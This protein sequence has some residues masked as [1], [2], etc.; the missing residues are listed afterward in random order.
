MNRLFLIIFSFS[1]LFNGNA[2]SD[3]SRVNVERRTTTGLLDAQDADNYISSQ[4]RVAL[5]MDNGFVERDV[6]I[7]TRDGVV[8]LTGPVMNA[9]V[10]ASLEKR[11]AAIEGVRSVQND[12]T[13]EN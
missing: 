5:R 8:T 3:E 1:L 7:V 11:A 10:K 2:F 13:I 6:Q 12:L 4:V 9:G